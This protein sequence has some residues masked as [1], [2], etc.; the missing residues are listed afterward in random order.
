MI[1]VALLLIGLI[2]TPKV[3]AVELENLITPPE[4]LGTIPIGSEV[5]LT[6]GVDFL[7]SQQSLAIIDVNF[8]EIGFIFSDYEAIMNGSDVTEQFELTL[9]SGRVTI[10]CGSVEPANGTL[11]I[12]LRFKAGLTPGNYTFEWREVYNAL[13]PAAV[14]A[15][16]DERGLTS[17]EVLC[18]ME[19]SLYTGWNLIGIPINPRDPSIQGIFQ[20]NLKKVQ[21]I[22]GWDNENKTWKIW[23]RGLEKC[24]NLNKLEPGKG[25]WVY[26]TDNFT[27]KIYIN[28][29][30]ITITPT[31]LPE[32][33]RIGDIVPYTDWLDWW[34]S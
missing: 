17:V 1:T 4:N 26:V 34:P 6:F 24:A 9:D 20:G 7:D 2:P 27:Q 18:G 13:K 19:I 29:P 22:Y 11:R 21:Y 8:S 25:Y 30:N 10:G 14:P 15:E 33:V 31:G 12:T 32:T 3:V 5:E 28:L 16:V 23:I